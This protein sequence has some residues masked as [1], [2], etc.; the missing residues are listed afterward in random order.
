MQP[1]LRLLAQRQK[2]KAPHVFALAAPFRLEVHDFAKVPREITGV[3]IGI[4]GTAFA[5][6]LFG[7]LLAAANPARALVSWPAPQD[8][9]SK[10]VSAASP[11]VAVSY[12]LP[13]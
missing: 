3:K 8:L 10:S 13:Q 6:M 11:E 1:Q 7:L 2:T 9:S 12:N 4:A 5:A